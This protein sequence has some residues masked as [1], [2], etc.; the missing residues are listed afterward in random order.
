M[1][2][3]IAKLFFACLLVGFVNACK[4]DEPPLPDNLVAFETDA[5]GLEEDQSETELN[6]I[7]SRA[8]SVPVEVVLK[9]AATKVAYDQEYTTTPAE[10]N[11]EIKLTIPAGQTSGKIKVSKKAGAV[12][13]GDEKLN[14]KITSAGSPVLLGTKS[15]LNLSFSAIVSETGSLIV[16]GATDESPY[17]NGVYVDLSGNKMTVVPRK[18]WNLGFYTGSEFRVIINPGYQGTA[19]AIDKTD[20]A[21]VTLADTANVELT[22]AIGEGSPTLV[23][24]WTG[25]MT[26]TAIAEVSA[27][28]ADNKVHLVSFEDGK[29]TDK[30][31]KVKVTRNSSGGYKVQYARIGET[32]IKTLDIPKDPEYNFI[33]A[34]LETDKIVPVEPRKGSWDFQWSYSTYNSGLNTPYWFQ[35]FILINHLGGVEAA[36]VMI[37]ESVTFAN[38]S[39]SGVTGLN[40]SKNRDAI[41]SKWRSGGGPTSGPAVRADRFYVIKDPAGNYYKIRFTSLGANGQRGRPEFEYTL[42]Q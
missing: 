2:H 37:S 35:D 22:F 27:T 42:L 15:E 16:S 28:D 4:E 12:L 7:L 26:K 31:F 29:T 34:S 19:K 5:A 8:E 20:L 25:D 3:L 11:G 6:V 21:A 39:K 40:F 24:D 10:S 17:F 30:W 9:V 13:N 18:S 23:D 38:F 14:F 36:E 41:G 32:A 1:K 33:F